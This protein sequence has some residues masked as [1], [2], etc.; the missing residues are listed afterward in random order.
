M[1][2]ITRYKSNGDFTNSPDGEVVFYS[3]YRM[4]ES[5]RDRLLALIAEC[6]TYLN[7]NNLT[8]IGHGSILHRKMKEALGQNGEIATAVVVPARDAYDPS[9]TISFYPKAGQGGFARVPIMVVR[10]TDSVTGLYAE[11]YE[12]RSE[13]RNAHVARQKLIQLL[14]DPS[15]AGAA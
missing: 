2:A 10:A 8:S 5:E 4:L 1:S 12:E 7:T 9:I 6:D 13:H 15:K 14:G 3:A 11:S